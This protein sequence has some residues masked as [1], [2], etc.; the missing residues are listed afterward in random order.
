[1]SSYY[2]RNKEERLE[3]AKEYRERTKEERLEKNK[4]YLQRPAIYERRHKKITCGCGG[5]YTG[6]NKSYHIKSKKHQDWENSQNPLVAHVTS[7]PIEEIV[8][9]VVQILKD[10]GYT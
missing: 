6:S 1:M 9:E 2:E 10:R 4:E 8:Q 5:K 3:Y 7:K